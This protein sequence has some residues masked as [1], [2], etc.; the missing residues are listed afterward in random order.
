MLIVISGL[1][2]T[3]KTA[4]ATALAERIR[5]T[6]LS[7]DVIEDAMLR[8]GSEPGWTTGV[9]AYLAAGATA[10][11]NLA[12]GRTVVVDAV[13]DSEEARQTWRDTAA[14]AEADVRFVLLLPPADDEHQR[15]LRVRRRGFE[16]ISEPS[17]SQV[18]ARAENYERWRDEPIELASVEPVETLVDRLADALS[19]D[20]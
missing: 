5:A 8:A 1:P 14:G 13:N 9:A 7:V 10:Q 3:G 16:H 17:W 19:L 4:L 11:Q 20:A 12:L 15:R 18:R 2:A 6:H